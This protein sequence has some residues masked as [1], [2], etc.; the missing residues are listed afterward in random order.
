MNKGFG[1]IGLLIGIAIIAMIAF[2]SFYYPANTKQEIKDNGGAS[3]ILDTAKGAKDALEKRDAD[4]LR[5]VQ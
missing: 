4:I 5:Q 3:G 2:G 1:L